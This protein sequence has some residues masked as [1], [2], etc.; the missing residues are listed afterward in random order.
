MKI[1][2]S[3]AI[4]LSAAALASNAGAAFTVTQ[5]AAA[6]PTYAHT[7]NF[8]EPGTPTGEVPANA[9]TS[10][11]VASLYTGENASASYITQANTTPGYGWLG[12]GNVCAGAYGVFMK[13]S[14]EV[15]QLSVQYWDDSGPGSFFGG[16]AA[17]VLLKNDV[18]VSFTFLNSPA[19]S[20]TAK[21]WFNITGDAG[22]SFDEIRFVGFGFFP[23]AYIDNVS[24]TSVPSPAG[25]CLLG[26]A[27]LM[28]SR[29]RR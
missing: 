25:A 29:R 22:D 6:A 4:T 8:D 5:S 28:G 14:G 18:E 9:F 3:A 24:W 16:G 1:S 11:G 21:P 15:S 19:F 27:G 10:Y 20:P 7:L 17:I 26:L 13:F 12:T 2:V 23:T